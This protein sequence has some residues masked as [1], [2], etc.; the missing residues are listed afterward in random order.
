MSLI[1][2]LGVPSQQR[3][4]PWERPRPQRAGEQGVHSQALGPARRLHQEEPGSHTER[5]GQHEE[6]A[7]ARDFSKEACRSEQRHV[8]SSVFGRWLKPNIHAAASADNA[9]TFSFRYLL[10]LLKH[11]F[12]FASSQLVLWNIT[13]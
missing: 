4:S 8:S 13:V 6:M 3:S 7:S 11:S 12:Y 5:R 1:A 2:Q 9:Y 10:P